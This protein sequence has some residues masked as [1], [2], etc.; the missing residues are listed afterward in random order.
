[1]ASSAVG[2][3]IDSTDGEGPHPCGL[4]AAD[5]DRATAVERGYLRAMAPDDDVPSRTATIAERLGSS[6]AGTS[7]ARDRLISKGV[8]F[9]PDRG[10]VAFTVPGMSSY[11]NREN[12]D[13]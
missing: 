7:R 3:A 10:V 6:L 11:I 4:N 9:A 8:I 5:W 2:A 13:R 1:M 12:S